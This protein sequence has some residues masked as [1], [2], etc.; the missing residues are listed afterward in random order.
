MRSTKLIFNAQQ[1]KRKKNDKPYVPSET[2]YSTPSHTLQHF[3][4]TLYL[5]YSATYAVHTKCRYNA[6][7]Y[8]KKNNR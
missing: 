1:N 6:T 8:I 5:L 3:C 7:I 2:Y 4:I